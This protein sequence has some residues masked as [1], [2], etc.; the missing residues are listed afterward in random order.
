MLPF[1]QVGYHNIHT[2]LHYTERSPRQNQSF[3]IEPTHQHLNTTAL[4]AGRNLTTAVPTE[5]RAAGLFAAE[6]YVLDIRDG[7]V[8]LAG[9][10]EA[11]RS[12]LACL[13]PR[14]CSCSSARRCPR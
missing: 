14:P 6:G 1:V 12:P 7:G 13:R 10:S 4:A 9:A 8:V 5:P 2:G 11:G 3:I